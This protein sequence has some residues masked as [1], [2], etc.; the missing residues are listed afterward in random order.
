ME[1]SILN[2]TKK[3]LGIAS[4]YTAFDL[5]VITHINSAFSTLTQLG[6]GPA[7][8]FMIEDDTAVWTDFILGDPEYNQVKSYVFLRVRLLFDPP[9][10]SYLIT[11]Y[12]DQIRELEWR[13]NTHRE[14]TQWVDPDPPPDLSDYNL[15]NPATV[16]AMR[17]WVDNG[18]DAI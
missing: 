11:A 2:S 1:M 17:R 12:Q 9:A 4:D 6:V 14:E 5:D 18:T 13:L 8:G 3:I 15:E 10:T 7:E 16:P